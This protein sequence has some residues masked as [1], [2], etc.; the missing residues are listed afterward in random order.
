MSAAPEQPKKKR[1]L[2]TILFV[3]LGL[4]GLCVVV[5]LLTPDKEEAA[6]PT[7]PAQ[8]A[9]ASGE[10]TTAPAASALPTAPPPPSETP[11]PTNTPAPTVPAPTRRPSLTPLPS[12]TPVAAEEQA[13]LDELVPITKSVSEALTGIG[14]LSQDFRPNDTAWVVSMAANMA[15]IKLGEENARAL[16][17]PARLQE[18]HNTLL[19]GLESQALAMD[20]FARGIDALDAALI[21]QARQHL[22]EGNEKV[23]EATAMLN[24]L[25]GR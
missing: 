4:L 25:M 15:A 5:A 16:V 14:T 13:Y 17:P 12:R 19:V 2:R 23:Q 6:E 22:A 18:M 3:V 7:L 1:S 9:A 24:T 8:V 11:A 10:S 20:Y 21:T